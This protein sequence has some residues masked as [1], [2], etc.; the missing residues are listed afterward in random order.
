MFRSGSSA[1]LRLHRGLTWPGFYQTQANDKLEN[2]QR[3]VVTGFHRILAPDSKV[4]Q[5]TDEES[6]GI[7]HLIKRNDISL[8]NSTAAN[9]TTISQRPPGDLQNSI[10][11]YS[12]PY[13]TC[14]HDL[15][16]ERSHSSKPRPR[17]RIA[18]FDLLSLSFGCSANAEQMVPIPCDVLIRGFA[19]TTKDLSSDERRLSN[20]SEIIHGSKSRKLVIG[21]NEE[22]R[23]RGDPPKSNGTWKFRP[24]PFQSGKWS[25]R[26]GTMKSKRDGSSLRKEEARREEEEER[27]EE[28]QENEDGGSQEYE[29]DKVKIKDVMSD[30]V[31]MASQV[32]E[33]VPRPIFPVGNTA[34]TGLQTVSFEVLRAPSKRIADVHGNGV[35]GRTPKNIERRGEN[36]SYR[37]VEGD[38]TMRNGFLTASKDSA[39]SGVKLEAEPPYVYLKY[40][41]LRAYR[42]V[43]WRYGLGDIRRVG[44]E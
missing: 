19:G 3:G 28:S 6:S 38:A 44:D 42:V 8:G 11:S 32:M 43:E 17:H 20:S 39:S 22:G 5:Q 21:G 36:T 10:I 15:H 4:H 33:I 40:V 1:G 30:N 37:A 26:D 13:F 24:R 2:F 16:A 27:E 31:V 12:N 7:L 14:L 35:E 23:Q 9:S 25:L 41:K 29:R 34:W 18:F